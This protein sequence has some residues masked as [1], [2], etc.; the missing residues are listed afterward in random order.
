VKDIKSAIEMAHISDN[1]ANEPDEG[2]RI[3]DFVS[4]AKFMI[5]LVNYVGGKRDIGIELMVNAIFTANDNNIKALILDQLYLCAR[6]QVS[7][8]NSSKFAELIKLAV[9]T[10][11]ELKNS[12]RHDITKKFL[13]SF[14]MERQLIQISV[15]T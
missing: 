14:E 11:S 2:C 10:Y 9:G 5:G 8:P 4:R 13:D 7:P 3:P 6:F 1:L 12:N 15:T